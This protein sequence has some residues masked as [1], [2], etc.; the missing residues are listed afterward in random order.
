M[1]KRTR[2]TRQ[3][4]S[5]LPLTILVIVVLLAIGMGMLSLG[6]NSRIYAM[7]TTSQIIA[8]CA[9]DAGL[10]KALFEM[11]EKLET[12]PWDDETLP[13][14]TETS[15]LGCDAVFS[16]E[17]TLDSGVYTVQSTGTYK[18][19][20]KTISSSLALQS[21][22]DSAIL[23]AGPLELNNSAIV[24]WYNYDADDPDLQ[25]TTNATGENSITLNDSSII[26]GDAAVGV[27][28]DPDND[29]DV[30]GSASI[31]GQKKAL[32]NEYEPIPVVLPEWLE[33]LSSSGTITNDTTVSS[34]G[35]YDNIDLKAG[36]TITIDNDVTLYVAGDFTLGNSAILEIEET[37]SLTVYIAGDL[38][39]KN[40]SALNNLTKEPTKF[41]I[42]GLDSC[43]TIQFKNS[44]DVYGLVYAPD[45][46]VI[47]HNAV[48]LYGAIVSENV[49]MRN[50]S[51]LMYDATL[52]D[53]TVDDDYVRFVTT[54][55]SEE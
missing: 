16:F 29:I 30:K 39:T 3:R 41:Q 45:T 2:Q 32:A 50:S 37:G 33:A 35:K 38:E 36:K 21:P 12:D 34:S 53:V 5:T 47:M 4:G 48:M 31:E 52:R 14:E 9:A 28:G 49:D 54:K 23:T 46:D 19:F 11:N 27:G 7:R 8:R 43:E 10:T 15:T 42:R 6:M 55:W 22:Y 51:T 26:K 25:A 40:S 18:G 1:K 24:D 13:Q 20:Q 17:V 44:S